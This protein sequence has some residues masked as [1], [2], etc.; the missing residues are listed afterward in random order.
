[1]N[2]AVTRI[3]N[4]RTFSISRELG[5]QTSS[6]DAQVF[7]LIGQNKRVLELGCGCGHMSRGLRDQGCTVVGV[8]IDPPAAEA[9][10]SVCERVIVGDLD[11]LNLETELAGERFDVVLA[12]DVLEHLKDPLPVLQ[13]VKQLLL[14]QGSIVISA[15]NVAH[16]SIRLAL[17]AGKFPYGERGLLDKTHLRFFTRESL[18]KLLSD[19]GLPI[20]EFQR[21]TNVPENPTQFEVPYDPAIVPPAMLEAISQD[22]D[23]TTYQFVVSAYLPPEFVLQMEV[24][25]LHEEIRQ[26]DLQIEEKNRQIA[27][28]KVQAETLLAREK[29]LRD[30]L[31]EA[32]DQLLRRDEEI[33]LT[34][35]ATLPPGKAP[36]PAAGGKYLQY[37][38][39]VQRTRDLVRR[40][41]PGG[42]NVL[43][44]SKGDDD[45]LRIDPCR[46]SHFPQREDGRYVGHHPANG[47]VA[48]EHLKEL[49][50]R[51]GQFLLIP[52]PNLWWLDHYRELADYL[53]QQ[54]TRV[55]DEPDTCVMFAI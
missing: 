7:R 24:S 40:S 5:I 42:S 19:A 44:V 26:R 14:P 49:Q 11:Y 23:A 20:R 34:L 46:G 30:M 2:S 21:I 27:G 51:G 9:A 3:G 32:H 55:I 8:E 10:A 6:S 43:I 39:V 28:L 33:A 45:L 35:A 22:P 31:L 4:F 53:N 47:L 54:C 13:S 50:S 25:R 1:M 37:Q 41:V 36:G 48:L 12:A 38:Q 18:E 52:Q 15:P 16:I 29:D 17:L